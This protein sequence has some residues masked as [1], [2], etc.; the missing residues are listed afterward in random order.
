MI[1]RFDRLVRLIRDWWRIDRVRISPREGRLL[2]LQPG[3]LLQLEGMTV[4]VIA[5][6]VYPRRVYPRRVDPDASGVR[7]RCEGAGFGGE[8]WVGLDA[9]RQADEVVWSRQGC[10]Q[11]LPA[12]EVEV[13]PALG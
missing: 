3:D 4:T 5:R 12:V 13:Y 11:R 8:L 6:Q 10:Q 7:Y 2:R 9:G 1:S